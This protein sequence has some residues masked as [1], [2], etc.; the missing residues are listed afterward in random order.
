MK[1]EISQHIVNPRTLK[2]G[3]CYVITAPVNVYSKLTIEE[4]VKIYIRNDSSSET[5]L[6]TGNGLTFLASSQLIADEVDFYAC[7]CHNELVNEAANGGLVFNGTIGPLLDDIGNFAYK[8][9][10]SNF[11]ATKIRCHYLGGSAT[12]DMSSTETADAITINNCNSDEWNVKSVS[13][14]YA[15][16]NALVTN[17]SQLDFE[18]VAIEYPTG[19]GLEI[20][21]STLTVTKGLKVK[22][23]EA[24]ELIE[25]NTDQTDNANPLCYIKLPNNTKVYLAGEW[26]EGVEVVSKSLPQPSDEPYY[27][28]NCTSCGQSYIFP[29]EIV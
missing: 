26:V 17:Q 24:G 8:T 23:G 1:N 21:N 27:F 14:K 29:A 3:K 18:Y 6:S 20:T 19:N 2:K 15:G 9:H 7:N 5:C 11:V 10:P 4:D 13:I 16:G 22:N 12:V 25:M 28:K